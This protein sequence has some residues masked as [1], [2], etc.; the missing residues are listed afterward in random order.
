VTE[1]ERDEQ[2]L[3]PI[4]R[5]ENVEQLMRT[6][7]DVAE[8]RDAELLVMSAVT[9]PEQTPLERADRFV[10]EEEAVVNEAMAL[11][12]KTSVPIHGLVR[13]GH[14][15]EEII[16]HTIDQHDCDAVVMG[17]GGQGHGRRDIALGSTVDDVVRRADSDVFVERIGA[18]AGSDVDS[19]LVPTAGG[20]H[21]ELAGRTGAAI[22]RSENA[23][24]RLV[25]VIDPDADEGER[26]AAEERLAETAAAI[27]RSAP[28]TDADET[29]RKETDELVAETETT[30]RL[31]VETELLEADDVTERVLEETEDHDVTIIGATRESRVHQ[32]VFGTLPETIG[33]KARNVT[34]MARRRAGKTDG[35]AQRVRGWVGGD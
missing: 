20:P 14:D 15:P 6:A 18:N 33:R 32:M 4:A 17:W 24:C 27:D 5:T 23:T 10:D 2:V 28:E 3:V 35:L 29:E 8:D 26:E 31:T 21:A 30:G 34:I 1:R 7:V 12:E 25:H 16:L 9:V 22:A 11:A 13:V 19:V